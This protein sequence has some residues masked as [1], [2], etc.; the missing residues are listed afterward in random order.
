VRPPPYGA[1]KIISRC[2]E[3]CQKLSR[4][5]TIQCSLLRTSRGIHLDLHSPFRNSGYP[6]DATGSD[7]EHRRDSSGRVPG[8]RGS[9]SSRNA[10]GYESHQLHDAWNGGLGILGRHEVE[11]AVAGRRTE[12][13]RCALV[14]AM[15]VDDDPARGGLCRR[16]RRRAPKRPL[17]ASRAA[18]MSGLAELVLPGGVKWVPLSVR[19]VWTL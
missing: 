9:S 14:D 1:P 17:Q 2:K 5:R 16:I 18:L 13:G 19:T 3:K 6:L 7:F 10:W 4:R 12:I 11:V 8:Y 15:G